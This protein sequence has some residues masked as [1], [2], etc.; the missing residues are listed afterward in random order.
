MASDNT[1]IAE[2]ISTP[3]GV[4]S[5]PSG[6]EVIVMPNP[7]DLAPAITPGVVPVRVRRGDTV[8]TEI[9]DIPVNTVAPEPEKATTT[10]TA[11]EE[12]LV[13]TLPPGANFANRQVGTMTVTVATN[14]PGAT[15]GAVSV[16]IS[17]PTPAGVSVAAVGTTATITYNGAR[18]PS[19]LNFILVWDVA[20]TATASAARA[21]FP[22]RITGTTPPARTSASI[23]D[24]TVTSL[25]D[26]FIINV[27][28]LFTPTSG[29]TYDVEPLNAGIATSAEVAGTPGSFTIT[30]TA[31]G[32]TDIIITCSNDGGIA[33]FTFHLS[34][35]VL[36]AQTITWSGTNYDAGDSRYEYAVAV[37]STTLALGAVTATSS[38][39][40]GS[41]AGTVSYSVSSSL[42]PFV[43]W[44]SAG[45]LTLLAGLTGTARTIEGQ[46]IATAAQTATAAPTTARRNIRIDIEQDLP[47][48]L[49]PAFTLPPIYMAI[50]D[51]RT[52][53]FARAATDPEGRQLNYS[54][55]IQN[56][57]IIAGEMT[58]AT[59]TITA[60][61]G[62]MTSFRVAITDGRGTVRTQYWAVNVAA[63]LAVITITSPDAPTAD[64][65]IPANSDGRVTPVYVGTIPF[66]AMPSI[67][68][69]VI[70]SWSYSFPAGVPLTATPSGSNAL[71]HYTGA[72]A[73]V[74]TPPIATSI[75]ATTTS[76]TTARAGTYTLPVRAEFIDERPYF[77]RSVYYFNLASDSD[78]STTPVVVGTVQATPT[79]SY[80]ITSGDTTRFAIDRNGTIT[81][82]GTAAQI[83]ATDG[84]TLIITA[85]NGTQTATTQ[86]VIT[87]KG[88]V[89]I[90]MATP[91]WTL[92][93]DTAG[94]VVLGS[95][96]AAATSDDQLALP[97]VPRL[98]ATGIDAAQIA[99]RATTHNTFEVSYTGAART[100][101][102]SFVLTAASAENGTA[103]AAT[104]S[105]DVN[106]PIVPATPILDA[107]SYSYSLPDG[108]DPPPV[109]VLG[110]PAITNAGDYTQRWRIITAQTGQ[111]LFAIDAATGQ[112]T[113]DG[114]AAADRD[115]TTSYM[116][117]I[118]VVNQKDGKSSAEATTTVTIGVPVAYSAPVRNAG[119]SPGAG[120]TAS[121][122]GSWHRTM[123][124]SQVVA[125]DITAG[126]TGPYTIQAGRTADYRNTTVPAPP[127]DFTIT[128][129]DGVFTIT[130]SATETG[131]ETLY[132]YLSDGTTEER[133]DFHIQV[134]ASST[135]TATDV[136][137]Y[138]D[139]G[140]GYSAVGSRGITINFAEGAAAQVATNIY[141]AY[142]D[143]TNRTNATLDEP[144]L[145]GFDIIVQTSPRR[146]IT[147]GSQTIWI[148]AYTINIDPTMFDYETQSAYDLTATLN[149]AAYA[150]Y[151]A[152]HKPLDIHLR[153]S[154]VDEP[155][156]RTTLATPADFGLRKQGAVVQFSLNG[157]W[158]DPEGRTL[159]YRLTQRVVGATG[160][161]STTPSDY[162]SASIIGTDFQAS[163]GQT[164]LITPAGVTIEF[165]VEA[166]DGTQYS[167]PMV[168]SCDEVHGRSLE[169]SPLA[170]SSGLPA[171]L[172]WQV[173]ENVAVPYVLRNDIFATSTVTDLT[174]TAGA[175]T[176]TLE[177]AQ[178]WP[179]RNT[180]YTF[181]HNAPSLV[182]GGT[183]AIDLTTA[184]VIDGPQKA[185]KDFTITAT[186]SN[187][188]ALTIT[189]AG[190]T[191]TL[192]AADDLTAEGT[193]TFTLVAHAGGFVAEYVGVAT[194][195]AAQTDYV[196]A[197]AT[198]S[199]SQGSGSGTEADP[200]NLAG[201]FG[202]V[203]TT[204]FFDGSGAMQ[205]Y[206]I[207][208]GTDVATA[209]S[210]GIAFI[211]ALSS[212]LYIFNWQ[213]ELDAGQISFTR[214]ITIRA[215]LTA[216]TSVTGE[217]T[218]WVTTAQ[219]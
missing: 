162:L 206:Q 116:L 100:A 35:N 195:G 80:A 191:A 3:A 157:F 29:V 21:F 8:A 190:K 181:A 131:S 74:A 187:T 184:F 123:T 86:A 44:S 66:M 91:V 33:T 180:A 200:W 92:A 182:A 204:D 130:A 164:S 155:P 153:V 20:E 106:V 198:F 99:I 199:P 112:I 40:A 30:P 108:T 174:A 61:A 27:A 193:S 34:V 120:W 87:V 139:D 93:E 196:R 149:V 148:D 6:S 14:P 213:I 109:Y 152:A 111:R 145:A 168:Y 147:V 43:Q 159:S 161:Q 67:S 24:R 167:T 47:P 142:T 36:A 32:E 57:A 150:T 72:P 110:T 50:G 202:A 144:T 137:W 118:G 41:V 170:W 22:A 77:I 172:V 214:Q 119:W 76:T 194:I 71:I 85:T 75:T 133:L 175:I 69:A 210:R 97:S 37:G 89:S 52:F 201:G 94:P 13:I 39:P 60:L 58:D 79:T 17:G 179:I 64:L 23:A 216:D 45:A 4:T 65:Q 138:Q 186:S 114:P 63:D 7:F 127:T 84:Y 122:D 211:P 12:V 103:L 143:I 203:P 9:V 207:Q 134:V 19:N 208:T 105:V 158:I 51:R 81:Y 48:V 1:N 53:D 218:L 31:H 101:A 169:D 10:I 56:T 163:A 55:E 183:L 125:I 185:G 146:Q 197:K 83:D 205:V 96:T 115:T 104:A 128:R 215:R 42:L 38:A 173:P 82:T 140:A 78:G 113:Y 121:A 154:D 178:Y 18:P 28:P 160:A 11:P 16:A 188:A 209:N 88:R 166:Y 90:T 141:A 177:E 171:R 136:V 151:A 59:G 54:I 192:T 126:A 212:E 26:S 102:L 176:Y 98:T 73:A 5:Y 117:Q 129:S 2:V 189:V 217:I 62:G 95:I 49:N 219:I 46:L 70:G 68:G 107:A 165:S 124:A 25:T 156:A 132:L 15:T 135:T